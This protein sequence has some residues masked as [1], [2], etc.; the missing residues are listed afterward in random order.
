MKDVLFFIFVLFCFV[1][2]TDC[3]EGDGDVVSERR[4]VEVF[5][6]V[7]LDGSADLILNQEQTGDISKVVVHAQENV[8]PYFKTDVSSGELTIDMVG[9][10]STN[11]RSFIDVFVTEIEEINLNGSGSISSG[12]KLLGKKIDIKNDGSGSIN[13]GFDGS[14][15]SINNDGSGSINIIGKS[16]DLIIRNDGSGSIDLSDFV[17]DR[18]HVI[19]SGSGNVLVNVLR[20]A[21]IELNGSGNIIIKGDPQNIEQSNHGSGSIKRIN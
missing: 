1:S 12:G 20:N 10:I 14:I 19:N 18:V 15:L 5:S 8:L 17:A 13:L 11:E 16:K 2:C 21:I 9:C 7:N 3:T 4:T 6:I